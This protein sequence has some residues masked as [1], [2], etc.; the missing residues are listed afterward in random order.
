MNLIKAAKSVFII[1][2]VFFGTAHAEENS[3]QGMKLG[4]G[5]DRGLGITG[6]ISQFNG[7]IGNDGVAVDYLFKQEKLASEYPLHWYIGGGGYID[8]DGDFGARLP[9]GA[10]FTFAEN[11]DAYAQ[12]IPDFRFNHD[13]EFGLGVGLGV[14]YRF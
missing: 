14:R 7:F 4:F 9:V 11:I 5:V 12:I 2:I 13:A 10:E 6:S 1:A 8:W 3:L